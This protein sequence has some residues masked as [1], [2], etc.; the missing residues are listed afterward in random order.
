MPHFPVT[1]KIILFKSAGSWKLLLPPDKERK[2]KKQFWSHGIHFLPK[3]KQFQ[4]V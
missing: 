3:A 4:K 2:V 1:L